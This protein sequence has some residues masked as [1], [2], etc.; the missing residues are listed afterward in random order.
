MDAAQRIIQQIEQEGTESIQAYQTER[1]A[2]IDSECEKEKQQIIAHEEKKIAM[3]TQRIQK[4]TKLTLER[5]KAQKRQQLLSYKQELLQQLFDELLSKM[6]DWDVESFQDYVIARLRKLPLQGSMDIVLGE[7]SED[8]L[9]QEWL[10]QLQL[11]QQS[12]RLAP[13]KIP[14]QGGFVVRQEKLEYNFLFHTLVQDIQETQ[15]YQ[16]AEELFSGGD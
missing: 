16:I 3:N 4:E 6:N 11:P 12:F 13:E 10:D 5:N 9:N 1:Q 14:H 7:Y 15:G 2:E 8:K